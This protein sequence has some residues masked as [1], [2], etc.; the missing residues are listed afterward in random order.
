M[1]NFAREVGF[2]YGAIL[3]AIMAFAIIG[4]ACSLTWTGDKITRFIN[5]RAIR[6]YEARQMRLPLARARRD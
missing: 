6:R 3:G 1:T 5:L 2:M 4:L